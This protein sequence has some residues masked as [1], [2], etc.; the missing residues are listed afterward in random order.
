MKSF[1]PLD[2]PRILVTGATGTTG[3]RLHHALDDAGHQT[4]GAA[5]S[6]AVA[7]DWADPSTYDRVLE[8]VGAAYLLPP[9]GVADPEPLMAS[10][11][12][13][14]LDAGVRRM[15]LLSASV[16]PE[17]S[18]GVGRVHALLHERVPEWTVLRPSW[19]MQNFERDHYLKAELTAHDRLPTS[20]Q[21]GRVAFV[22]AQDIAAVALRALVDDEPH[23][24]EHVIT[25]PQALSYDDIAVTLSGV[26]GRRITHER[27]GREGVRDLMVDAG[28]PAGFAEMLAGL[29]DA[30]R[31]GA[32]DRV[33]D[34]VE[35]VT[36]RPPRSFEAWA[37]AHAAAWR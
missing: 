14:A 10:F 33:T 8:R 9:V 22:D 36:G 27:V 26:A 1:P 3:S 28:M 6:T 24:A 35:R 23:Q 7:F 21:D 30:L 37:Q 19:F 4:V 32:E 2:R 18:P 11:V 29:E 16:V 25:G 34:T 13:R 17:G 20:V 5:R 31:E 15:V 12:E